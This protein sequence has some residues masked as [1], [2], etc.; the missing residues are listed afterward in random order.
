MKKPFVFLVAAGLFAL[1]ST[2][3]A[4][5][6]T[7]V[8]K[9][10]IASV[11]AASP[12]QVNDSF[13][14]LV[15]FDTAAAELVSSNT[16]RHSID[17][18]ALQFDYRIGTEAWQHLDASAGGFIYLRDNQVDPSNATLPL[19]DGLT[20]ALGSINIIL[21]WS[22][23]TAIDYSQH[24]MPSNP[25]A[26]TNLVANSFQDNNGD[27]VGRIDSVSAVPEATSSAMLLAG[28]GLMGAVARRRAARGKLLVA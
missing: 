4:A 9:G 20:F 7:W 17:F 15:N 6:A 27:F 28:L 24:L 10:Y 26:L 21:R 19:V 23:L 12:Y 3:N 14:V 18:S 11:G 2:A 25:P 13:E 8:Y 5:S 16:N 22:D 1:I